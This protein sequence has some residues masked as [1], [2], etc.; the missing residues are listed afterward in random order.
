MAIINRSLDSSEQKFVVSAHFTNTVT[1]ISGLPVWRA[2]FACRVIGVTASAAG[3]SGSP[4]SLLKLERFNIGTGLSAVAIAG[5]LTHTAFGTSGAQGF[6]MVATG[7]SLLDMVAGD[8]LT[9]T[10]GGTNSACGALLVEAVVQ[11][12]Q[13]IKTYA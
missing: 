5:A 8:Q 10:T 13:D 1:G 3:V 7:S 6:S 12:L 2:P 11:A 4:T 9:I